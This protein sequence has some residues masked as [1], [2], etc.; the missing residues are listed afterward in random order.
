MVITDDT[1][2]EIIE[3]RTGN[4]YLVKMLDLGILANDLTSI[5]SQVSD[6]D[7]WIKGEIEQKG[8]KQTAG[9]YKEIVKSIEQKLGI[10]DNVDVVTRLK[11]LYTYLRIAIKDRKILSELGLDYVASEPN[12]DELSL[13]DIKSLL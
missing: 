13:F 9:A 4:H 10:S 11:K 5:K 1:P 3:K 7:L 8:L 6:I 12:E 2:I